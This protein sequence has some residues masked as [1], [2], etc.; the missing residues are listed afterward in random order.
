VCGLDDSNDGGE[1]I[2]AETVDP[3]HGV[4]DERGAACWL[5]RGDG[6]EIVTDII[7]R[8]YITDMNTST[9]IKSLNDAKI[10]NGDRHGDRSVTGE[11]R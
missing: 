4:D 10:M 6:V 5:D 7:G 2:S 9:S 11:R 1:N 8:R 3:A